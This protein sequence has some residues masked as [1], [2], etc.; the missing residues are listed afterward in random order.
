MGADREHEPV[1]E[2]NGLSHQVEM[3]IGDG[4][5]GSRKQRGPRHARG[6]EHFRRK[7]NPGSLE[8]NA[9]RAMAPVNHESAKAPFADQL[10]IC[11]YN[12][13]SGDTNAA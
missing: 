10:F 8:P 2:P 1:G 4:I 13:L 11:Y 7:G 5:E 3:A 6:L 9:H 12:E